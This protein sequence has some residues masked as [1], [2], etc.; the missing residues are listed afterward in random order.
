MI[1]RIRN[2]A[3]IWLFTITVF[4]SCQLHRSFYNCSAVGEISNIR[5]AANIFEFVYAYVLYVDCRRSL[6]ILDIF[7]NYETAFFS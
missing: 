3:N 6:V 7:K 1:I 5:C 2:Y 4:N